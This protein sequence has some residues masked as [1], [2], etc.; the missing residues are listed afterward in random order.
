MT[1]Q[2]ELLTITMEECGELI[3]ACS[4]VI[5]TEG[6]DIHY[7]NALAEE[8]GDVT[9]MINLLITSGHVTQREIDA[10]TLVK[11]SKLK[12]WSNLYE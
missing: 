3:Q 11:E 9:T 12:R 4:K 8:V 5:R 7:W 6:K 2:E 10:R 1:K